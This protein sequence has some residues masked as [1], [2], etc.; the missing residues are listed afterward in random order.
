MKLY[1][2]FLTFFILLCSCEKGS[3]IVA[4]QTPFQNKNDVK[5]VNNL[6]HDINIT[7]E[8]FYEVNSSENELLNRTFQINITEKNGILKGQYCAIAKNGDKIDCSDEKSNNLSGVIDRDKRDKIN[9]EFSSFFGGK[10]GKAEITILGENS[11]NWKIIKKVEGGE[12][13]A[14]INCI[15]IKKKDVTN[16]EGS[17]LLKSCAAG[18]FSIKLYKIQQDY[19]FSVYDKDKIISKGTLGIDNLEKPMQISLGKIGGAFYGDSIVIQNYGNLMNEFNN[20]TQCD[21]KYLSFL[22]K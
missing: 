7:G 2:Y 18:R 11:I 1:T 13:Y 9:I 4:K 17:Y 22:K 21:E 15:L 6:N 5:T 10:D 19:N 12:S 20:F 8:W 14:P 16:L 3:S